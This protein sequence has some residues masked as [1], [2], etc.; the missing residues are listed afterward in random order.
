MRRAGGLATGQAYAEFAPSGERVMFKA[1]LPNKHVVFCPNP[2]EP[3]ILFDQVTS[4]F[5]HGFTINEKDTVFDVGANIGLFALAACD[6]GLRPVRIFAFEPIPE[7]FDALKAN[8]EHYRIPGI[9]P[10]RCAVSQ[11]RG[12]ETFSYYPLVTSM[13]TAYPYG[14]DS[15]DNLLRGF[16]DLMPQLPLSLRWIE[17]LPSSLQAGVLKLLLKFIFRGRRVVC[18]T[19]TLSDAIREHGV[20][21]IDLLKIDVEMAEL[22]VLQGIETEDWKRV[23]KLVIEVHDIEGRL[24]TVMDMLHAHGFQDVICEQE[25][26]MKVFAAFTVFARRNVP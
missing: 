12:K 22:Q 2:L 25:P 21:Q 5:R 6:W 17:R 13:S 7:T 14:A 16:Q 9:T 19:L 3:P 1:K 4:Y 8:I 11:R 26:I 10:L 20:D 18:E 15:A 23:K 24:K